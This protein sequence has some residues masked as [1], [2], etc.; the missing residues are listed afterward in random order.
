MLDKSPTF[1]LKCAGR[2]VRLFLFLQVNGLLL[3]PRGGMKNGL[4]GP[5]MMFSLL[6]LLYIQ[7]SVHERSTNHTRNHAHS[8]GM[9]SPNQPGGTAAKHIRPLGPPVQSSR[10]KGTF[11]CALSPLGNNILGTPNCSCVR[12]VSFYTRRGESRR[13]N[14]ETDG[15]TDTQATTGH[16]RKP[17]HCKRGYWGGGGRR[18]HR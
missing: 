15:Q 8:V 10:S 17:E 13:A 16:D 12:V 9:H 6:L 14:R 1:C 11:R 4:H 7:P 2:V 5:K 3:T 18:G